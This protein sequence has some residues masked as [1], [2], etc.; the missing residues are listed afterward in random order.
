MDFYYDSEMKSEEFW[1]EHWQEEY[2]LQ[3]YGYTK[4]CLDLIPTDEDPDDFTAEVELKIIPQGF[5]CEFK[6]LKQ[7]ELFKQQDFISKSS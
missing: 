3:F 7:G 4:D 5:K 6:V 2:A 1:K